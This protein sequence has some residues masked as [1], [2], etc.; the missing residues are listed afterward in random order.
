MGKGIKMVGSLGME[1]IL[2][3][4][5]IKSSLAQLFFFFPK[6]LDLLAKEKVCNIIL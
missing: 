6:D 2:G 1:A 5:G 4:G 3:E